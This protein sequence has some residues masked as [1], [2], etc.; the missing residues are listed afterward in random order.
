MIPLKVVRGWLLA[1]IIFYGV[2]GLIVWGIM[3]VMK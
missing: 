1:A 2:V 3:G